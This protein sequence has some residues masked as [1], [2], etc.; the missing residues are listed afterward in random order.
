M[1]KFT[2]LSVMD[3]PTGYRAEAEIIWLILDQ[4]TKF[5][6]FFKLRGVDTYFRE[7]ES[8]LCGRTEPTGEHHPI[9]IPRVAHPWFR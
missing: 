2:F 3:L 4:P 5:F 7:Q 8:A 6:A 1:E 9:C